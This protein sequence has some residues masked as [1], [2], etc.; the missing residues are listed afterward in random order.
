L[1]LGS[2]LGVRLAFLLEQFHDRGRS[3]EEVGQVSG[4]PHVR[5]HLAIQGAQGQEGNELSWSAC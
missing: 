5:V 1:V 3:P 2:M 4:I